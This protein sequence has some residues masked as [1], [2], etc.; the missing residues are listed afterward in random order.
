MKK[1]YV[2]ILLL[3]LP[4]AYAVKKKNSEDSQLKTRAKLL[5]AG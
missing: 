5:Q 2:L 4:Q 1:N 3:V